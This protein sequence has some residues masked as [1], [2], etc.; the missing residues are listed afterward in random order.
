MQGTVGQPVVLATLT[1]PRV[2]GCGHGR[3]FGACVQSIE[4][5]RGARRHPHQI[6]CSLAKPLED[7]LRAL[8]EGSVEARAKC[9][10]GGLGAAMKLI[11]QTGGECRRSARSSF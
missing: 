2:I 5:D 9:C 6:R 4:H 3:A 1:P 10:D 8:R 11:I 7:I